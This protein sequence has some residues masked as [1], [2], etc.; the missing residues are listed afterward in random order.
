M[1]WS[2]AMREALALA[3]DPEAPRGRNPRV[4]CVVVDV[5]GRIVGRGFH[6]GAGTAHAEIVALEDAGDRARG[7]TA[8]VTLEPCRHVGRTGPCA[9]ALIEAGITR[10]V[11][12]IDDPTDAGGGAAL[13]SD[14]GCEV[15]SGVSAGEAT[16]V[17]REWLI[18]AARGWPFV[19]L[20]MAVSIDGRV[21]GP[22]G[23]ELTLTG[24]ESRR[25]VHAL[26]A[27]AQAVMVGTG[28]VVTDDPHLT[29]RDAPMLAAGPPTRVVW[30]ARDIPAWANIR[31]GEAPFHHVRTHDVDS[32][33]MEL[34]AMGVREVLVEGGPTVAGALL[35]ADRV[36]EVVW[37]IAPVY[38]GEGPGAV[39]SPAL[40]RPLDVNSVDKVGNDVRI[41]AV[42]GRG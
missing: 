11:Y 23:E 27:S 41:I 33:L 31:T 9:A 14:A 22:E 3:C 6:R 40:F 21:A 38:L 18:A 32:A 24:D 26:R 12:A 13:L 4:G 1:S 36:D 5:D 20:K 37:L 35:A 16:A 29:V 17:N 28:T 42:P 8:V 15:T 25:Y 10:V 7:A 2:E 30:G 39:R 34:F 19:R